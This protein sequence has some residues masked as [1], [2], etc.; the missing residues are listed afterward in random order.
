MPADKPIHCLRC[1]YDWFPRDRKTAP[2]FCARCNSPYWN[3][4]RQPKTA[5]VFR[6]ANCNDRIA[7]KGFCDDGCKRDFLSSIG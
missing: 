4:P 5:P 6:C 2:K 1:E 7:H 3:K